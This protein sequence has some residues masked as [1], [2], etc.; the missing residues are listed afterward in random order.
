MSGTT[1]SGYKVG[2]IVVSTLSYIPPLTITSTGTILSS[3]PGEAAL[4]S[5]LIPG[6]L[7]FNDG[8][9]VLG[10]AGGGTALVAG[11]GVSITNTGSFLGGGAG[12]LGIYL[13]S[14][15]RFQ[16]GA[17]DNTLASVQNGL[18]AGGAG[19]NL[20]LTVTSQNLY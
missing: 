4:V 18:V 16:N 14:G 3:S 12:A 10:A 19:D 11:D 6:A 5:T 20:T 8:G 7:I 17:S 1:L 15:A 9:L 2:S 13:Q